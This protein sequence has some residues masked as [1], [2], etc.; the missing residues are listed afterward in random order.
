MENLS[1]PKIREGYTALGELYGYSSLKMNRFAHM[2]TEANDQPAAQRV[3]AKIGDDWDHT[4]WKSSMQFDQARS[5]ANT[6]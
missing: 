5:R 4:V 2:A 6:Q 1:W 3:F